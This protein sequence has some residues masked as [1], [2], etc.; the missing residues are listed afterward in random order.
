MKLLLTAALLSL[1]VTS[2]AA[3]VSCDIVPLIAEKDGYVTYGQKF[4]MKAEIQSDNIDIKKCQTITKPDQTIHFCANEAGFVGGFELGLLVVDNGATEPGL[5]RVVIGTSRKNK[6]ETVKVFADSQMLHGP[7]VKLEQAKIDF[8]F[9][10]DF[11]DSLQ[12]E[13]AVK[14][15]FR[16]N[17]LKHNEI[18]FYAIDNCKLN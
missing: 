14:E 13:D 8:P 7:A 10:W 2:F 15:G 1:S 18:L 11:A 5:S 12:I 9:Y 6:K 4:A 17:V 16:L 3:T